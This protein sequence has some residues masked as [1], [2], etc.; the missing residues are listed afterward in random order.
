VPR[1]AAG[2]AKGRPAG[3]NKGSPAVYWLWHDK[4]GGHLITT[5]GKKP[6]KFR[7][8][9]KGLEGPLTAFKPTY[10]GW[11]DKVKV[12]GNAVRFEFENQGRL[13]GF[14]WRMASGCARFELLVDGEPKAER[15]RVGKAAANPPAATFEACQ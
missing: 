15:I 4:R 11:K 5:S 7:G 10:L 6:R 14:T 3:L 9:V 12:D 2:V 8:A 13:D 1:L